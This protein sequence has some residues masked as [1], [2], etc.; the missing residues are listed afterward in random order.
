M[1]NLPIAPCSL[2][3]NRPVFSGWMNIM[4]TSFSEEL[5]LRENMCDVG[6]CDIYIVTVVLTI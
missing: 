6:V 4:G 3:R 5:D 2:I 1:L